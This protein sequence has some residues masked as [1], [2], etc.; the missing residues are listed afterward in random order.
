MTRTSRIVTGLRS[1]TEY[2]RIHRVF[3]H[4][5]RFISVTTAV[6]SIVTAAVH[7]GFGSELLLWQAAG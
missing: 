2:R 7:R 4:I 3:Q 1:Q 6:H 5:A